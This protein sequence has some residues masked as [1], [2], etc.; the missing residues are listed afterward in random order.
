M[1]YH[2]VYPVYTYT[3]TFCV[4]IGGFIMFNPTAF[5]NTGFYYTICGTAVDGYKLKVMGKFIGK[6]DSLEDAHNRVLK[7]LSVYMGKGVRV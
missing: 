7:C 4:T 3:V 5:L 1:E 6:F 2:R